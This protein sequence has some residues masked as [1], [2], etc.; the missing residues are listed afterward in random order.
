MIEVDEK[1]NSKGRIGFKTTH[2]IYSTVCQGSM[3]KDGIHQFLA[4]MNRREL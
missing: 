4:T 1:L 2:K 3:S